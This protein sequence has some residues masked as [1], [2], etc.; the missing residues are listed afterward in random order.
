M[1]TFYFK[2]IPV[3]RGL[4]G[5]EFLAQWVDENYPTLTFQ[6]AISDG[7]A[8]FGVLSGDGETM[9]KAISSIE[10][11]FSAV[12]IPEDV[13]IGVCK[14]YYNP[15]A[16]PGMP[17]PPSFADYMLTLGITVPGDT[18]PNYKKHRQELLKEMAKKRFSNPNDSLADLARSTVLLTLWYPEL[19]PGE[20][21]D[22]DAD[23]ATLKAI[24]TKASC[25][26]SFDSMVNELATILS[27]YYT[28]KTNIEAAVNEAGV[29][30]VSIE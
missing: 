10:G 1:A 14:K 3:R 29:D 6:D 23:I 22:V 2:Y 21:A 16:M 11:K 5:S 28:A 30:A 24:Y 17:D 15:V 8:K 27:S 9:S 26:A 7:I 13:F 4:T 18:L 12:R 19:T 20:K 25:I